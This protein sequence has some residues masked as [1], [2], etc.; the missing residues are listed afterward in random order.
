MYHN[1]ARVTCIVILAW[2]RITHKSNKYFAVSEN[3]RIHAVTYSRGNCCSNWNL[4]SST[5]ALHLSLSDSSATVASMPS[6][7]AFTWSHRL[8]ISACFFLGFILLFVQVLFPSGVILVL[9]QNGATSAH[10]FCR[11]MCYTVIIFVAA[12]YTLD[13]FVDLFSNY[14]QILILKTINFLYLLYFFNIHVSIP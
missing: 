3:V 1:L 12:S 6:M 14:F 7:S 8:T 13:T 5:G 2:R 9:L 11:H 10:F 4:A